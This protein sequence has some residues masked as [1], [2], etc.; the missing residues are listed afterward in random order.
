MS[1]LAVAG[2]I[3]FAS[4]RICCSVV[5]HENWSTTLMATAACS[6]IPRLLFCCFVPRGDIRSQVAI[7]TPPRPLRLPL[8]LM[9]RRK[10]RRPTRR[11]R[12][13][14]SPLQTIK[15][16][17]YH[18]LLAKQILPYLSL[19]FLPSRASEECQRLTPS[20]DAVFYLGRFRRHGSPSWAAG[21]DG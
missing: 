3:A 13:G 9:W 16:I 18:I 5:V 19:L 12:H 1:G 15:V 6:K 20:F 10:V 14:Q 2:L 4:R 17:A 11:I 8:S 7:V 21:C